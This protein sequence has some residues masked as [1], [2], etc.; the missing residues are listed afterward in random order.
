MATSMQYL[1]EST[2]AFARQL[3]REDELRSFRDEFILPQKADGTPKI[4]FCGNSLGLQPK[5]A[6]RYVGEE[7]QRWASLA[8]EGHFEG[9][10]SW[11][12]YQHTM[13]DAT[14]RLVGAL[15]HEVVIMN[16]LTVN[17]HLMLVSFYRPTAQRYKIIMEAG[18]FPSD[19]YAVESQ[20]KFH[21]FNPAA[22]IVEIA[23][24]QGESTLRTEDIEQTIRENADSLALVLFGGI[25]YYTGQAFELDR[26]AAAAKQAGAMVGFDLA[27]AA[28]NVPMRLH[29]WGAD[30]AV[31]C[32]Y[33]YLNSGPGGTS[34]VFIH[35]RH[36]NSPDLPR[37]AGWWGYREETRFLMQ[38]GF[39]PMYGADGWQLSCGQ[40][41]PFAAHRASLEIF[42]RAGMDKLRQKSMKLTAFLAYLL[43][44][45]NEQAGE[46]SVCII[47][48]AD[49]QH[50]GCQL[51]LIIAKDGKKTF[52]KLTEAGVVCDWREPDVIRVAPAPLYNT[53]EEV[54]QFASILTKIITSDTVPSQAI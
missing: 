26:I 32:T 17:L 45:I 19:Q 51:S 47:T 15:P 35:E 3:D 25:H 23:P 34:G 41:L 8:V 48:P 39:Q 4:Y 28:G 9:S 24:R 20:V 44:Q 36:A 38:K 12:D 2:L 53:F 37:F 29:E 43:Q 21:G 27:H 18:A 46:E 6:A 1:F 11:F 30:F 16:T 33:K 50:R 40:I 14:A 42:D 10:P 52:Q 5:A 13:K 54:W 31:W 7:M 49:P 22:A